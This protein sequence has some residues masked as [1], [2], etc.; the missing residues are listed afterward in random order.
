[1]GWIQSK[2]PNGIGSFL[3]IVLRNAFFLS[4]GCRALAA[5]SARSVGSAKL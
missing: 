2:R 3:I 5:A 4:D 1:M